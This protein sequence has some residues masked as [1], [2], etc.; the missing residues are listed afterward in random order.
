MPK[1]RDARLSSLYKSVY[2]KNASL[3]ICY[4]EGPLINLQPRRTQLIRLC[5]RTCIC[6]TVRCSIAV[7]K[8]LCAFE[9]EN[10]CG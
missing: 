10:R 2:A 5:V 3:M 9:S 4:E 6:R 1:M 7:R 8:Q